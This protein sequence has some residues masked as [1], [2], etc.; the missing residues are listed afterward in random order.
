M[1]LV[2][3]EN[4]SFDDDK[5]RLFKY[6]CA[7]INL[8]ADLCLDRNFIAMEPLKKLYPYAICYEIISKNLYSMV[9]RHS[10]TRLVTTLWI[11]E[12]FVKIQL[13]DRIRVWSKLDQKDVQ[14]NDVSD[15]AFLKNFINAYIE[16][17]TK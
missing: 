2:D 12:K 4:R 13:P 10:F 15:F 3:F 5:G 17:I 16:E 14:I 6:F 8:C 9:L 11:D 7:I 1:P